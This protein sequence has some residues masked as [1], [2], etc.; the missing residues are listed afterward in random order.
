MPP[1][2]S[3]SR[4]IDA[5]PASK[6]AAP[7]LVEPVKLIMSMSREG[8]SASPTSGRDPTTR[9]TTPGG[10]PTSAMMRIS[11]TM[12]SGSW[13]AGFITIVLPVASA[14]PIFPAMLTSGKL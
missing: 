14:G 5:P 2:S 10:N 6:I 4:F 8:T 9:F 3:S 7:T 13:G 11:S 1:S 12:A